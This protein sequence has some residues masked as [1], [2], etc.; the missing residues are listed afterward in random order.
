M[1]ILILRIVEK[2]L[3]VYFTAYLVI[4]L[5][6]YIYSIFIFWRK[7]KESKKSLDY[8]NHFVSIIVPAYNEDVSIVLC[9]KMLLE[10][11]YPNF[12]VILVNDGSRDQTL[13]TLYNNFDFQ[14]IKKE[15]VT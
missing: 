5:T 13:N 10:L 9:T 8:S 15:F 2:I 11:D 6:L 1:I 14:E 7:K 4:D 12:E 3:I